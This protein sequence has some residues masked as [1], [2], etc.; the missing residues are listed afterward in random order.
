MTIDIMNLAETDPQAARKRWIGAMK[1]RGT[2][3]VD[4]GAQGPLASGKSL[5]PA[6]VTNVTGDFERGD[7]V[8]I[9][10]PDG[11]HLGLGLA[12]YS[13]D[14]ARKI[15][16]RRSAEIEALLGYSGRSVLIHR[17]DMVI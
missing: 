5:L 12:R 8:E 2:I 9:L 17:D 4:A 3:T 7:A 15:K 10:G 11:A 1:S 13:G 14:E 16:G 6:G